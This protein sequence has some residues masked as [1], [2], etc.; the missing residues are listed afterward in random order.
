MGN[1]V[2]DDSTVEVVGLARD[3]R[4]RS[5]LAPPPAIL[6]LP[7]LQHGVTRTHLIVRTQMDPAVTIP[8]IVRA[9]QAADKNVTVYGIETMSQH[10][11]ASLWQQRIAEELIGLLGVLAVLL[12]SVGLYGIIAH[13]VAERTREIGIRVAVGRR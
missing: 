6:Y 3:T 5:L 1:T 10:V 11:A 13:G 12:A 9:F 8:E 2:D 4:Y 7:V